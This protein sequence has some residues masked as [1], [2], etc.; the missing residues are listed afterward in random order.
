MGV[1]FSSISEEATDAAQNN[2]DLLENISPGSNPKPFN[3]K[4]VLLEGRKCNISKTISFTFSLLLA[5]TEVLPIISKNHFILRHHEH[6][7]K[8][9]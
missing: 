8:N 7:N 1:L 9:K 2:L 5:Q 6:K 3:L 4:N